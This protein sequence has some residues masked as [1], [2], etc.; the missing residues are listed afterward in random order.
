SSKSEPADSSN[1][2]P[3]SAVDKTVSLGL[4]IVDQAINQA[5]K[6][7]PL[8]QEEIS[9]DDATAVLSAIDHFLEATPN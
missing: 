4:T 8:N 1:S 6:S 3:S 7:V 2:S 9:F 5:G